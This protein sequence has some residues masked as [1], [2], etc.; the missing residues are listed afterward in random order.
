MAT[1]LYWATMATSLANTVLLIWLGLT[2]L[3]NAERRTWGIWLASGGLLVGGAFFVSHTAILGFGIASM[4]ARIDFW[5]RVGLASVMALPFAWYIIILWYTGFWDDRR[6]AL[7]R[8]QRYGFALSALLTVSIG[9]LMLFANPFP[10]YAQLIAL[11][12]S[13]TPMLFGVPLLIL[14]YPPYIVLTIGLS[15]DALLRP[16]PSRRMMGELARRRARPWLIAASAGLLLV[17]TGTMPS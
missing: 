9:L 12:F 5:W 13:E 7:F 4:D 6:A 2:V 15:L 3:L 11:R 8:R 14:V 17:A 10:S 1:L 16:E